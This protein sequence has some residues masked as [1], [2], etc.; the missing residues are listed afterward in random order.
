MR[1]DDEIQAEIEL[2]Y[3]LNIKRENLWNAKY[4]EVQNNKIF[5]DEIEINFKHKILFRNCLYYI[6]I[7]DK[8]KLI[9]M[10]IIIMKSMNLKLMLI[11]IKML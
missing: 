5:E 8:R 10:T 9:K 11:Q 7:S 3:K 4:F 6:Y 1:Q 2:K